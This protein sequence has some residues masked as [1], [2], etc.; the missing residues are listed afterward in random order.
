M[1]CNLTICN[2]AI[3]D[4]VELSLHGGFSALTGETGAGKSILVDAMSLTLGERTSGGVV[5]AG[6]ERAEVIA[7]FD[8]RDNQA[9]G[10][11]LT[12]HEF[13]NQDGECILRRVVYR[14][15]RTRGFIN[16]RPVPIQA[17]RELGENLV[18]IYGQHD[19]QALLRRDVQRQILDAH[20]AHGA[21]LDEIGELCIRWRRVQEQIAADVGS[22]VDCDARLDYLRFQVNELDDLNLTADKLTTLEA[23]HRRLSHASEL[24]DCCESALQDLTGDAPP[25]ILGNLNRVLASLELQ[26]GYDDKLRDVCGLMRDATI[27][28]EEAHVSLRHVAENLNSDPQMLVELETTLARI[29]E[30]ARKHRSR[31]E[32]LPELQTQLR[33]EIE[34]L[35]NSEQRLASLRL[36]ADAITADYACLCGELTQLRAAAGVELQNR[37]SASLQRLG[38]EGGRFEVK[39]SPTNSSTPTPA[40]NDSIEFLV[41]ANPGQAPQPLNQVASGG[42][43]SRI[44]LAI[45]VQCTSRRAAPTLIFDEVDA[46]VGGRVA[47]I[48]GDNLRKLS[49]E[50]QVLCVTHLPQVASLAH[51]HMQ[52]EK[53]T[54]GKSTRTMILTLSDDERIEELARMLGGMKVTAQSMANARELLATCR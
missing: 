1:L 38:M 2:Y 45:Q 44:S 22:T 35:E 43:L 21:L 20:G 41:A 12:D 9:A 10:D 36:D 39:L 24:I 26:A 14:E 29:H 4:R 23:E 19:H 33:S 46:G 7:E 17:L 50:F 40:G 6:C 28:L 31:E 3:V 16:G 54:D 49:D 8:I 30:L 25:A 53:T 48:V 13:S 51:H 52:V 47:R 42:E 5:R 27:T 32:D 37:I 15:G 18:D 11:W 34:A